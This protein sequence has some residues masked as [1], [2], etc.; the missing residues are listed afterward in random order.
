MSLW[1]LSFADPER[2]RGTQFLGG[3]F[4]DDGGGGFMGGVGEAHARGINP[5]G[6]V[7]GLPIKKDAVLDEKWVNRL[8]SKA[9]LEQLDEENPS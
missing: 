5:G 3:V 1:Y 7:M 2:P 4:V 9:E 6:E 8:L